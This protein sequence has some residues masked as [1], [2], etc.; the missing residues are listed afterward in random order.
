ML[1]LLWADFQLGT[2][3]ILGRPGILLGLL[4][5]VV[6]AMAASELVHMFS[7]VANN[8]NH[9]MVVGATVA[10][11]TVTN[12]PVLWR[13]YPIDCPLGIFGWSFSGVVLAIVIAF[14]YEMLNYDSPQGKD[15][16][17]GEVIDRLGRCA[18]IFLYLAMLFGFLIPHR[19]LESN[20]I[21][22]I[23]IVAVISTVKLSDSFAYFAGKRFGTIK[24]APKLSP[25]KTLQGGIGAV[26]GGVIAAFIVFYLVSPWI[27]GVSISKPLWWVV[28][29]GILVTAAG[30]TGDLAESLIKRD[31]QT[32]D[33][34]SWLP[35]LGGILDITDSL[36]F[37][38]P[39]SYFLWTIG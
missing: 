10:M 8:V 31:S 35:G 22:L 16:V 26:V 23:A 15:A 33:S 37:A 28:L 14:F 18:L 13:E 7:N 24:L 5:I 9:N 29:F 32:K 1:V 21:G 12:M 6:S 30:M 34:S 17:A 25:G 27:F 36:V 19:F 38:A 3:A 2:D 11:V 39:I 20:Q 4:A